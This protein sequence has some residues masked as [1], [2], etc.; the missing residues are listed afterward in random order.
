[1]RASKYLDVLA[2]P[3]AAR[4]EFGACQFRRYSVFE[5]ALTVPVKVNGGK[6]LG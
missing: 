4:K 6:G 3:A 2:I 5:W 1:M